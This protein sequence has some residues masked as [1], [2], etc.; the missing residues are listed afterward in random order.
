MC[1]TVS[2]DYSIDNPPIKYQDGSAYLIE[3]DSSYNCY[4]RHLP[5]L[6]DKKI[7]LDVSQGVSDLHP[8]E[9]ILKH[10]NTH[11]Q[12]TPGVKFKP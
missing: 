10:N 2:S 4:C 7:T 8:R 9:K 12:E 1:A 5:V 6:G 11:Y 3:T